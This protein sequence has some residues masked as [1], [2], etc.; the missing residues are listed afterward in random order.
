MK[1]RPD[2]AARLQLIGRMFAGQSWQTAIAESQ[3]NISRSTAYRLLQRARDEDKA[4]LVFLDDRHGHPYKLTE[5]MPNSRPSISSA[6][7]FMASGTTPSN[8]KLLR[9]PRAGSYLRMFPKWA[10][11]HNGGRGTARTVYLQQPGSR[12]R[13]RGSLSQRQHPWSNPPR[14]QAASD[15]CWG[16]ASYTFLECG[17]TGAN[18][19]SLTLHTSIT[20][21]GKL[22]AYQ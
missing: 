20:R 6:M 14:R 19:V 15:S 7:P 4:P 10:N 8:L 9:H 12:A 22:P 21:K 2:R 5:P 3:L 16:A 1:D 18:R 11:D 13:C 17:A